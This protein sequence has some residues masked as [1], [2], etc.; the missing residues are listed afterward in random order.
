M[1]MNIEQLKKW[2][3]E[4]T[5]L[6]AAT[7]TDLIGF[8]RQLAAENIE[9]SNISIGE[10]DGMEDNFILAK[11]LNTDTNNTIEMGMTGE[12]APSVYSNLDTG[13]FFSPNMY[14]DNR[15]LFFTLLKHYIL[16]VLNDDDYNVMIDDDGDTERN[17]DGLLDALSSHLN[18]YKAEFHSADKLH[19]DT[20]CISTI[21]LKYSKK[22]DM[23]VLSVNRVS[24][25]AMILI[26]YLCEY[27][28][29]DRLLTVFRYENSEQRKLC[30]RLFF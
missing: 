2:Y 19:I 7:I 30:E 23:P 15:G 8:F 22:D 10:E 29:K 12:D 16:D 13:N 18:I 3:E 1:Q 27:V 14:H 21:T 5:E 20:G 25:H 24:D 9:V 4:K 28:Y 17:Y 6:S 11:L 26:Q